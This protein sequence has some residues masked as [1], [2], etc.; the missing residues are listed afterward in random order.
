M[1]GTI[2]ENLSGRKLTI[3]VSFLLFCQLVC[4]L[5]GGLVGKNLI[6][7]LFA[8]L[9]YIARHSSFPVLL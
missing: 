2:L 7:A 5:I 4:F 3:L 9:V 6:F 8:S 1:A